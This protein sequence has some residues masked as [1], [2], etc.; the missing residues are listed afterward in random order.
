MTAALRP[1]RKVGEDHD[2]ITVVYDD[3]DLKR[4]T[5]RVIYIKGISPGA[6]D[7]SVRVQRGHA[8]RKLRH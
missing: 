1:E 5:V 6:G 2:T 7:V 3:I 4:G 8:P